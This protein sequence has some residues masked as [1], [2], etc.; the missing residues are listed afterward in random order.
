[1]FLLEW[2]KQE[3]KLVKDPPLVLH[4]SLSLHSVKTPEILER[5]RLLES[6]Y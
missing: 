5:I 6:T 2:G 4:V 3:L 1:M